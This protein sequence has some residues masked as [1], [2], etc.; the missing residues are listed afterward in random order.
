METTKKLAISVSALC[1]LATAAFAGGPEAPMIDMNGIHIGLGFGYKSYK[2]DLDHYDYTGA[3]LLDRNGAGTVTK[4]GPLGE[5]GYTYAGDDWIVGLKGQ[6]EFDDVRNATGLSGVLVST[7]EV[8]LRS[9]LT[10][11]LLAG[12]KVNEANAVYLEAGY[13]AMFVQQVLSLNAGPGAGG[14]PVSTSYTLN[15]G[16]VGIGWRHYFENNVFVDLS[17]DFALYA[18]KNINLNIPASGVTVVTNYQEVGGVRQL[19][20][21]GITATANYLFNV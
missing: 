19:R 17:Y 15:G 14:Q 1:C 4:F 16:V 18:D 3:N 11:M 12:L 20:V 7:S 9:H 8:K 2:Y 6:F 5:L 13:T 21:N 10:A